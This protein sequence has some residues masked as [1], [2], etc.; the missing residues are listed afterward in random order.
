MPEEKKESKKQSNT[1]LPIRPSPPLVATL[2]GVYVESEID[3][4][5]AE[6]RPTL[7]HL[8]FAYRSQEY[9]EVQEVA[10]IA[11]PFALF[12]NT[13]DFLAS[14]LLA[15]D[16]DW[17]PNPQSI[18]RIEQQLDPTFLKSARALLAE[19]RKVEAVEV[20]DEKES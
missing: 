20:Y 12:M 17:S 16:P 3:S 10:H 15:L 5:T 14:Y 13:L 1:R 2:V 9:D 11:M 6:H 4:E 19:R 7:A 18:A 8:T